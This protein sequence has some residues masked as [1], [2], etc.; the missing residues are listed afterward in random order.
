MP[1]AHEFFHVLQSELKGELA[2]DVTPESLP[3]IVAL[4]PPPGWEHIGSL[5][6]GL[7]DWQQVEERDA[8]QYAVSRLR[9]WRRRGSPFYG[10]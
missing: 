7:D 10:S 1:C 8:D 4:P 6:P 2:L 5:A 9:A 3:Q